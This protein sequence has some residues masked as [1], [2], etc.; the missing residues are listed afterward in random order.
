[1]SDIE[2][3]VGLVAPG[4]MKHLK[5]KTSNELGTDTFIHITPTKTVKVFEPQISRRGAWTEDNKLPRTNVALSVLNALSAYAQAYH[6]FV[7]NG[8]GRYT[9]LGLKAEQVVEP[10]VKLVYDA[11]QTG[12]LWILGYDDKHRQIAP[13]ELG[14]FFIGEV[15]TGRRTTNRDDVK[16][17][18]LH[19]KVLFFNVKK[20]LW[21]DGYGKAKRTLSPGYY[22]IA[23]ID[24]ISRGSWKDDTVLDIQTI[25]AS[26]YRSLFKEL[27]HERKR[28]VDAW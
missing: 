1:M 21:L 8:G 4:V 14:E 28:K 27:G 6:D 25:S 9:I 23:I 20:E 7:N 13:E 2:E 11:K 17:I 15:Y 26:A 19:N 10:S 18:N 12:E 16:T 22:R 24:E 3:Y 5:V